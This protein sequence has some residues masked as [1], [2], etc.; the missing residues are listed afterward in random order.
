MAEV[1]EKFADFSVVTNDNPRFEDQDVIIND[2]K[3]GFS[4]LK[5]RF[6]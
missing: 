2:I 6:W 1:S 4:S 3:T 5:K